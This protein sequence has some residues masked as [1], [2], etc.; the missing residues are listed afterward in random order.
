MTSRRG[1]GAVTKV[2]DVPI[3]SGLEDINSNNKDF[4]KRGQRPW[5]C[6]GEERK[7]P[8]KISVELL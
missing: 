7:G 5:N 6:S 2:S 4:I 3:P 8:V 1:L